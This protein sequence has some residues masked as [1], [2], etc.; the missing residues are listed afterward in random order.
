MKIVIID[1]D[2]LVCLS[3]KTILEK[4]EDIEVVGIGNDGLDGIRLYE[5]LKPDIVLMDIRMKNMDGI[6]SSKKIFDL[7]EEAKIILLTTFADNEYI[8]KAL[9]VGVKGYLLKDDI[10]SIAPALRTV[11][12]GQSVFGKEIANMFKSALSSVNK[13]FY[14]SYGL[15]EREVEIVELVANGLSNKEIAESIY[16]SEGTIRNYLSNILEKLGLRDRTQLAVFYY[17]SSR[18]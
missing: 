4:E 9:D 6:K 12:M 3:L 8:T 13:D 2:P 14:N 11:N 15:N 1:D 16:L 18:D 10:K 5:E 17:K 7:D